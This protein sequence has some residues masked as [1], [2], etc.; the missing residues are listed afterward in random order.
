MTADPYSPDAFRR[1]GHALIEI[2]ADYLEHTSR[3]EGRVLDYIP[4]L[5]LLDSWP[6]GFGQDP[7]PSLID[8]M[9]RVLR[10]SHH[11]HHPRYI[12]HQVSSPL[13]S[14]A[15]AELVSALLNNGTAEYEMGPVANVMERRLLDW[16]GET[17]GFAGPVEGMLTSGGSVG[18]LTALAAARQSIDGFDVWNAGVADAPPLAILTSAHTHYSIDRAARI[19]GLGSGGVIPVATDSR[20]RL[21]PTA[22]RD[23][24]LRAEQGGRRVFV[25]VG[26]ACSTATGAFD[27]L[28]AIADY[29]TEHSLWFHVDGA[30]GA[31]AALTPKYSHLVAGIGRADSVIVDAHK[32]LHMPALVTAVL[33]G[34]PGSSDRAFQQEQSYV[35]FRRDGDAYA[36]WD[37]GLRTLECTK[38][39][40]ALELY[41]SLSEHGT[42]SFSEYVQQTF[43][44]AR[45]FADL[46]REAPDFEF[47]VEPQANIVCFRYVR[48]GV[49]ELDELQLRIREAI[50]RSGDFYIVKTQLPQ[51]IHLRI[52]IMNARTT[53]DDLR[54]LIAAVRSAA[55]AIRR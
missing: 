43:D 30:H 13:P 5:E 16:L 44:L 18:N 47:P 1:D 17:L 46:L 15:L 35:G 24:H 50:V 28:E 14:A 40:M 4:P 21:D 37:S 34:R 9:P 25:V 8:L 7:G 36:W 20:F 12:G 49:S 38:R 41:A 32:M 19:L 45:T 31:P 23:A 2:L 33:F 54:A 27:P 42:N 51:G 48:E 26:S 29:A 39:M 55:E 52:T 6:A 22:L 11:L 10:E 3:R 53:E